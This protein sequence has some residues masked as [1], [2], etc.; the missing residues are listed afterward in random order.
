MNQTEAAYAEELQLQ[1]LAG[2]ILG[3]QFEPMKLRL[4]KNTSYSPDFLV[5]LADST[6]EFREVK[7]CRASGAFLA[8]DDAM[9]KIKVAAE[10]YPMFGFVMC[11]KLPRKAGWKFER[12]N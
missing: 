11:G 10:M 7:A 9:V 12:Y 4:A 6:L 1:L 8:E 3:Y 5:Q 2:E